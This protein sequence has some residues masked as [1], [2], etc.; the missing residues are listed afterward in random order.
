MF[1]VLNALALECF[2]SVSSCPRVSDRYAMFVDP[3]YI[4]EYKDCSFHCGLMDWKENR[5]NTQNF[6]ENFV[7]RV[8]NLQFQLPFLSILLVG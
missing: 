2:P 3:A 1:F 4:N 7:L 6:V 5:R 8:M